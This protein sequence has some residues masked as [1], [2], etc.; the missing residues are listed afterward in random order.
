MITTLVDTECGENAAERDDEK[1]VDPVRKL[2]DVVVVIDSFEDITDDAHAGDWVEI[3]WSRSF[4]I[5]YVATMSDDN[6]LILESAK[7]IGS[8]LFCSGRAGFE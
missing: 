2:V 5:K 4:V 1:N 6:H 7:K 3:E 8:Q